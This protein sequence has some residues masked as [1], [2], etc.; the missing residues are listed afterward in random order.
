MRFYYVYIVKCSDD[1]LYAG[2]TNNLDRRIKEHNYGLNKG[3]YTYDKRP[4]ELIF[5]QEFMQFEQA[6]KFE[7]KIKKWSRKKKL[8]LAN[9]DFQL[10]RK[11]SECKN[12]THHKNFNPSTTSETTKDID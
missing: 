2:I 9:G 4:V 11:L 5:H 8:A 10:L 12:E 3:S 7:K 6:E 1:S